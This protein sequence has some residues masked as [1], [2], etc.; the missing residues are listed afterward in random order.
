MQIVRVVH[1]ARDITGLAQ[2]EPGTFGE[3]PEMTLQELL[4]FCCG[5]SGAAAWALLG[6]RKLGLI[7][8]VGAFLIG[9][10]VGLV[11]GWCYGEWLNHLQPRRNTR[12]LGALCDITVAGC[13]LLGC[14]AL[15][16]IPIWLHGPLR[17]R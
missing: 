5:M 11:L 8:G 7:G 2:R 12:V 3:F 4:S 13:F 1:S 6:A 10:L 15:V 9:G 16:I 14:A 17:H